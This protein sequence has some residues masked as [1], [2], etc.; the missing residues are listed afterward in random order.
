ME[1]ELK[2]NPL[3][4]LDTAYEPRYLTTYNSDLA[5]GTEVRI[6]PKEAKQNGN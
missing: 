5:D 3:D 1:I 6:A 2:K 4:A